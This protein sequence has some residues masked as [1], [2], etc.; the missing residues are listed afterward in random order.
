[1]ERFNLETR[2]YDKDEIADSE[3]ALI[4]ETVKSLHTSP[5]FDN[6]RQHYTAWVLSYI[7]AVR[8]GSI[9]VVGGFEQGAPMSSAQGSA[10]YKEEPTLTRSDVEF[11][12]FPSGIGCTITFRFLKG[13]R[14]PN[15]RT[16]VTCKLAI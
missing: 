15:K 7:T 5:G 6:I 12:R 9:T 4:L 11:Q 10:V 3:L 13:H 14:G 16:F 2:S 1:L 8:P